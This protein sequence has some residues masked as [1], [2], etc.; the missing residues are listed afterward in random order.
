[1]VKVDERM[2]V[3]KAMMNMPNTIHN[4][5]TTIIHHGMFVLGGEPPT[6]KRV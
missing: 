1:M 3:M 6:I 4:C 5:G 2:E